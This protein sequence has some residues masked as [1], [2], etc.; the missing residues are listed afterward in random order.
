MTI[1]DLLSDTTYRDQAARKLH[2]LEQSAN[3]LQKFPVET[4]QIHGL[5][6]N[7][8]TAARQ[9]FEFCQTPEGTR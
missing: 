5:R 8:S 7:C 2:P 1:L 6:E 3:E 9:R 4:S